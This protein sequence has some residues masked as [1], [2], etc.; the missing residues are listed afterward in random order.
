MT[1]TNTETNTAVGQPLSRVDG[2]LKV[3]GG[4]RYAADHHLPGLVHAV[5]VSSTVSRGSVAS[6][7]TDAASAAPG[8][9]RVLSDFGAVKLPYPADRVNFFGQSLAVVVASGLEQ[10]AHAA[11]LVEVRYGRQPGQTDLDSPGA[12]E[13]PAP[14]TPDYQRGDPDAALRG[15]HTV[16]DQTYTISRENH[17]PMELAAT[18]AHW[19]GDTLTLWD[20]T[21]WVQGTARTV[22]AAFGIAPGNVRVLSPFVGGAFGSAGTTWPHQILAAWAAREVRQPVK[23]VLTRKQMYTG[24]GYRPTSRQRLAIGATAAGKITCIVHEARQETARYQ[25]YV[26]SITTLPKF[27]YDS[28]NMRSTH[29]LV[30]L[31]VHQPTYMRGPGAVTGAFAL[32][33]AVD[34]LAHQ[35]AIDP[36][37]LRTG[38]EPALDRFS[39]LPFSSRGLTACFQAGAQAFGWSARKAVPRADQEGNLLIGMGVA[40]AAYHTGRSPAS[41][42]ARINADG[43]AVIASATSDMGPGTYTSMAQV[44]ADALGMPV[45]RVSLTLGDSALPTAPIHAGSQTMASV[46]SAVLTACATLRDGLVRAA[47]VDPASPLHGAKPADI[48]VAGGTLSAPG[49]PGRTDS[50]QQILRRHGRA[51]MDTQRDWT[52]GDAA[53]HWSTYGYGAVFA[54]VSVDERLGLIRVRRLHATYDVG[55]VINPKL[56]HSQALGGM[57]GGIGMSLLESTL[58]DHRD[59]RIV[60]ANMADYLVPV[61]ADI[62]E[63]DVAFLPGA[64]YTPDPL[65]VKGLGELVIVGVPAAIANAV[66]NATGVRVRELPIT[67]DK[68][69][70]AVGGDTA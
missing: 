48:A 44:A 11:A 66:F 64:D 10:A 45:E 30:P 51:S 18:V 28:P 20:K 69:L 32:E 38:N 49:A 63:L 59:G 24:T 40:G 7:N 16:V 70:E 27:L 34:E 53:A 55:R 62:G 17:N 25:N 6:M 61:N 3:T 52:P 21:Q 35:L 56:A 42:T 1:E 13:I 57:V 41:A 37:E 15:A 39:N 4:A 68:V 33:S 23:L 36:I 31:D 43:T 50:Y 14:H 2:R 22:A 12:I 47:V 54:E 46:G 29:R 19:D 67:L 58:R 26:D 60:N 5:I 65:G 8:V 9:L